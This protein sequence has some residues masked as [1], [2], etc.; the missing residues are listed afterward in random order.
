[1]A[2]G[3]INNIQNDGKSFINLRTSRRLIVLS[4]KG[5]IPK[6]SI[7]LLTLE[8]KIL[9]KLRRFNEAL[10]LIKNLMKDVCPKDVEVNSYCTP[11]SRLNALLQ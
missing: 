6:L 3:I 8:S 10:D 11:H 2:I 4:A 5:L 9:C 1:M 7:E